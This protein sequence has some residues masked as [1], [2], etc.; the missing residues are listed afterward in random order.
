[1]SDMEDQ[2]QINGFKQCTVVPCNKATIGC[3]LIREA[4]VAFGDGEN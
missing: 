2:P 1:M 4:E 3:G